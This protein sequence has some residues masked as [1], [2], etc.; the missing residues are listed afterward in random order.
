[1][2]SILDDVA[3]KAKAALGGFMPQVYQDETQQD[4]QSYGDPYLD[5]F[6]NMALDTPQSDSPADQWGQY[7]PTDPTDVFSVG[8]YNPIDA[9]LNSSPTSPYQPK[10]KAMT[11]ANTGQTALGTETGANPY[12]DLQVHNSNSTPQQEKFLSRFTPIAEDIEK[13]YGIPLELT[14]AIAATETGWGAKPHPGNAWFGLKAQAGQPSTTFA[15]QEVGPNGQRYDTTDAFSAYATPEAAADDFARL[16][17]QAPRY[18]YV[19]ELARKGRVSELPKALF[20]AGYATDPNI[21]RVYGDIM[22]QSNVHRTTNKYSSFAQ[23]QPSGIAGAQNSDVLASG[24]K[25]LGKPYVFGSGRNGSTANFDC[26]SFVSQAFK[27][28][29]IKLTPY[30]DTMYNETVEVRPQDA[31]PGDLVFWRWDDPHQ[32][33]TK[34]SHVALYKGDGQ[35]LNATSPGGVQDG[36]ISQFAGTPVFRRAVRKR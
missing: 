25:Y 2:A 31:Q 15:T 24:Y 7:T 27:D 9:L 10:R 22:S 36:Y 6:A 34:Y 3:N 33:G 30:T 35:I 29:G 19:M 12:T 23:R 13:R 18:K 8:G 16:I 5:Y 21:I 11:M 32:P 14:I 26:S 4:R 28:I 20:D 17:T 1:M